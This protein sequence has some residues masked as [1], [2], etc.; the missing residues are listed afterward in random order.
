MNFLACSD[1]LRKLFWLNLPVEN[2]CSWAK[3]GVGW[4]KHE[5][6]KR[7]FVL[8]YVR[9]CSRGTDWCLPGRGAW[10]LNEVGVWG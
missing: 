3:L 6:I 5:H 1:W 9:S 4:V 7:A 10:W 8:L 2:P